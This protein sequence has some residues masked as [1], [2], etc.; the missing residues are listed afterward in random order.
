MRCGT[1]QSARSLIAAC[2]CCNAQ[3]GNALKPSSLYGAAQQ[4]C[5][6]QCGYDQRAAVSCDAS[7]LCCAQRSVL[8]SATLRS[9]WRA[10]IAV[11][12]VVPASPRT[13]T[14]ARACINS[15]N[16]DEAPYNRHPHS[17]SR[18]TALR[19]CRLGTQAQARP[20]ARTRAR[21]AAR[22]NAAPELN[23][24][25]PVLESVLSTRVAAGRRCQQALSP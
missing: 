22:A 15:F 23:K 9:I 17:V 14:D 19:G 6:K 4:A 25:A 13:L 24:D 8:C 18:R 2:W 5:V 20:E 10:R 21:T 11:L 1:P 12:A 7:A 3:R 16:L